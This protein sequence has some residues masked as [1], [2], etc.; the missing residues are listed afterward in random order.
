MAFTK[1]ATNASTNAPIST[2]FGNCAINVRSGLCVR[3]VGGMN[4][5][6]GTQ[7][8]MCSKLPACNAVGAISVSVSPV[9][10]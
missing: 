8:I 4:G 3:S 6:D 1:P 9:F 10:G 2:H 5:F 7:R